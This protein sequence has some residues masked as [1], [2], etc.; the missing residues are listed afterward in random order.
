MTDFY[1]PPTYDPLTRNN[2][3]LEGTWEA[4]FTFTWQNLVNYLSSSGMFVPLVTTA[5]R[6]QITSPRNGQMIY[7]T[8]ANEPQMW[9]NGVWKTM[10]TA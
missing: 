2:G 10:V 3:S 5:Q 9:V 1:A 4:W 7:N 6:N 8:T